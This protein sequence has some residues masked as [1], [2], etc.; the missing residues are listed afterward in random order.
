MYITKKLKIKEELKMKEGRRNWECLDSII[1]IG[2]LVFL[3]VGLLFS[4]YIPDNQLMNAIRAILCILILLIFVQLIAGLIQKVQQ[5][6]TEELL[7]EAWE[8]NNLM[9]NFRIWNWAEKCGCVAIQLKQNR[10]GYWVRLRYKGGQLKTEP[11]DPSVWRKPFAEGIAFML[12]ALAMFFLLLAGNIFNVIT[13]TFLFLLAYFVIKQAS[14]ID[15][16]I[17]SFVLSIMCKKRINLLHAK[18]Y[19][20]YDLCVAD[21]LFS[22]V[23]LCY[24]TKE[25]DEYEI[26]FCDKKD[27]HTYS[28]IVPKSELKSYLKFR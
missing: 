11:V 8:K 22:M 21:N 13:S 6:R 17:L 19:C 27:S 9:S 5:E 25:L 16:M 20:F 28:F 24:K 1:K 15:N 3:L 4:P 7:E 14:Q 23:S 2:L 26:S 12:S 10:G 18:F